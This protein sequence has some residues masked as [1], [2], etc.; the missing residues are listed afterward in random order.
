[1]KKGGIFGSTVQRR[2]GSVGGSRCHG[3]D[4]GAEAQLINDLV[5]FT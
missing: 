4:V 1:M 5:P 2:F 3:L